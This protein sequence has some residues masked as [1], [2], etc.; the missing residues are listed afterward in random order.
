[1]N[2]NYVSLAMILILVVALVM[3]GTLD[4]FVVDVLS[5]VWD[6]VTAFT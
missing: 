5:G 3:D 6:I 4:D 1:M 2:R